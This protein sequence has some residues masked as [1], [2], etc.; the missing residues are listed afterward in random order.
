MRHRPWSAGL[1][2]RTATPGPSPVI[3]VLALLVGCGAEDVAEPR[4]DAP[5]ATTFVPHDVGGLSVVGPADTT[6]VWPLQTP[7]GGIIDGDAL[8]IEWAVD[9]P[10]WVA[11]TSRAIVVASIVSWGAAETPEYDGSLGGL[12]PDEFYD[13]WVD[14]PV[15]VRVDS[16]VAG[17]PFDPGDEF[18]FTAGG[19]LRDG[20]LYEVDV[21][22]IPRI[23]EQYLLF[24]RPAVD[25]DVP[26]FV[27]LNRV[28]GGEISA[29]RASAEGLLDPGT[30]DGVLG[31]DLATS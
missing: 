22:P 9:E 15:R 18:E 5:T 16:A 10:E 19:Y 14:V 4:S 29:D 6:S 26:T 24:L 11:R 7:S 21:L 2:R 12:S 8:A 27:H 13:G 30:W 20:R 25:D 17:E 31:V 1:G 23:G 28:R 3:A